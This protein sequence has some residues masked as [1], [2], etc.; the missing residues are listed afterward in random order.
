MKKYLLHPLGI[1]I[2]VVHA[3]YFFLAIKIGSIYLVDSYGYLNQAKNIILHH[4]TYAEDWNALTLIDYF[5]IRPPLYA[6]IIAVIKSIIHSDYF[7]IAYQNLLSI[8][9]FFMLWKLLDQLMVAQRNISVSIVLALLLFP[10]QLIHANFIMTEI[11]FQALLMGVFY[12]S[13]QF[14][15]KPVLKVTFLIAVLLSLAMLTKPVVLLLGMILFFLFAL[16]NQ[17]RLNIL[18]PFLLLPITY[19]LVCLQNKHVTGYYHYSSIKIMADV[20]VNAKYIIAQKYGADSASKFVSKVFDEADVMNDYESRYLHIEQRCNEVYK[21]N[22]MTFALLYGKGMVSTLLDPGRFDLAVFF[23]IQDNATTGF[24]HRYH[25]EGL[26]AIPDILRAQP[27]VLLIYLFF[28]LLW[29]ILLL[30]AL[31]VF[32]FDKKNEWIIRVLVLLFVGYIVTATGIS[33]LCRYRVPVF[34]ELIFAF[35]FALPKLLP[36]YKRKISHARSSI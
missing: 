28:I 24:L 18:L 25:T 20:R 15:R 3:V 35:A 30:I 5:T 29:N 14:Y 31:G 22:K 23:G 8:F 21:Q 11:V 26:R 34:P 6:I 13:I 12:F 4:S 16:T 7:V 33:G 10:S 17:K 1:F 27:I 2:I 9:T 32:L 36:F 19:H